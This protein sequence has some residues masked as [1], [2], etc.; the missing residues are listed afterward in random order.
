M[1]RSA[2]S[3]LLVFYSFSGFGQAI[4]SIEEATLGLGGKFRI[5]RPYFPQ[6][7]DNKRL[8]V[9]WNGKIEEINRKG[10]RSVLLDEPLLSQLLKEEKS[11][12]RPGFVWL[13]PQNVLIDV[14][15]GKALIDINAQKVLWRVRFPDQASDI[16]ASPSGE[17]FAYGMEGN[18]Y[19]THASSGTA[20]QI[21]FDG[22][23]GLV[24]GSAVHRQEF[25]IQ[26]GL[27]WS[28]NGKKLAF[29]KKDERKVSRY[30]LVNTQK[31]VAEIEAIPYPMAGMQSEEV[32][33][34]V[35]DVES[36]SSQK[37]QTEGPSDQYLT[38]VTWSPNSKSIYIGLLNRGQ[39]TLRM[40]QYDAERGT[41]ERQLFSET[42]STWVEP[43]HPLYFIP[44][45]SGR[46][47][48]Q[49][50]R[51]GFNHAYLY[52]SLGRLIRPL[53]SGECEVVSIL[54]ISANTEE[55]WISTTRESALYRTIEKVSLKDGNTR[56]VLAGQKYYTGYLSPDGSAVFWE[57]S[58]LTEPYSCGIYD[59][60]GAIQSWYE[61]ENPFKKFGITLPEMQ[62]LIIQSADGKTP[63]HGRI[64]YPPGF[65]PE[66]KYPAIVYVY[67]GPH[68]QL[69]NG[70]FLGGA[71]LWDY[72]MA[73]KGYIMLTLDNRG[74]AYRG[75]Q[76]M[77]PIHRNL[78]VAEVADQMMG[79][80]YLKA[81]GFIDTTKI[82]VHGWS[83]GGFM[84]LSMATK[85]PNVFAAAVAGGPVTDWKWYE[86][87]Y[88]ERYMDHPAENP[89]GYSQTSVLAAV[90]E[91]KAK[92]LVIHGAQDDVVVPQH[93]ME[94][95]S[96][97]I[98]AGK[99][100]E[101]FLYPTHKHNVIGK[102]RVHLMQKIS[103]FFDE[104][105]LE[106]K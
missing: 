40:V 92:T 24:N 33:L 61:A 56:T 84:T 18:I 1:I 99:Q 87:M 12:V 44:G 23:D 54:G 103:N 4:M 3:A 7:R 94:F 91:L 22:A 46:F 63:L 68:A 25:G 60:K 37:I 31:R 32:T 48:W 45:N 58:S 72:Y 64:I 10:Q 50:E 11:S 81:S 27:F 19:I 28:P 67:G 52:D 93:A 78:G 102:D 88:G 71:G 59:N 13:S 90:S 8:T 98:K 65:S 100:V 74:S 96:A 75:K 66:K 16:L 69:V 2:L 73:S 35:Y 20:V 106:T 86:V 39:D 14:P 85:H 55:L 38:A 62:P 5:Q 34:W 57:Y 76:F 47:I 21:T 97:S 101:L 70:R 42:S 83:F 29:Y 53:T 17:T 49:S 30:P 51:T 105:L 80:A 95:V 82:G 41:L 89:E 15:Q 6:W 77:E 104:I 36:Q 26:G 9:F 43:Q 79:I